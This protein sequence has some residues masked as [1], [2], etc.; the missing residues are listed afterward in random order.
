MTCTLGM[1]QVLEHTAHE[2]VTIADF[3]PATLMLSVLPYKLLTETHAVWRN[4]QISEWDRTADLSRFFTGQ[5]SCT[6]YRVKAVIY[7]I[8]PAAGPAT[9]KCGHYVAHVKQG[10]QWRLANDQCVSAVLMS[11]L[12]GLF[13]PNKGP[14]PKYHTD[15][16]MNRDFLGR[17]SLSQ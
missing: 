13:R 7:H 8:H 9:L 4:L 5:H 16:L 15:L 17:S 6:E 2:D 1:A 14:I 10:D 3:C 11:S 12:R